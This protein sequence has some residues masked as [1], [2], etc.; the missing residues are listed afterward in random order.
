MEIIIFELN[1]LLVFLPAGI[2]YLTV[3]LFLFYDKT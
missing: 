2:T 3:K 1:L